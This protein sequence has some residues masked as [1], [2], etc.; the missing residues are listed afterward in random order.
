MT[1]ERAWRPSLGEYFFSELSPSLLRKKT[2]GEYKV[3]FGAAIFGGAWVFARAAVAGRARA[4]RL[5]ELGALLQI[6]GAAAPVADGLRA[7]ARE[8]VTELKAA[9]V[10]LLDFW[11]ASEFPTTAWTPD[12][13]A[14]VAVATLPLRVAL[15]TVNLAA[16]S[17]VA[18][19]ATFPEAVEFLWRGAS[20]QGAPH[21]WSRALAAGVS[22]DRAPEATPLGDAES[23]VVADVGSLVR[24][25]YPYLRMLDFT[26]PPA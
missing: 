6:A 24:E 12:R 5:D 26:A 25:H 9:P 14:W 2:L 8:T 11:L 1:I 16:V 17:G 3:T 23:A 18:L 10:S 7:M 19:G 21:V 20:E 22:I 4:D 15:D 13:L